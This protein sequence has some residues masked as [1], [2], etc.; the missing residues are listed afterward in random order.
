MGRGASLDEHNQAAPRRY[1]ARFIAG[2][3]LIVISFL[4]YPAYPLTLLFLPASVRVKIDVIVALSLLSWA[5]FGIGIFLA[6]FQ[7]YEWLKEHWK[8]RVG[9]R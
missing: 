6:G 9:G 5:V 4:V 2:V 3:V 1:P 8:R 7:G